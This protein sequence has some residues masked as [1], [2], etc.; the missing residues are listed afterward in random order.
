MW[1]LAT[2][3]QA[4]GWAGGEKVIPLWP[5]GLPGE[6]VAVGAEQATPDGG[7]LTQISEPVVTVFLPERPDER[8]AGVIVC[9]GGAYA[10]LT[11]QWEGVTYAKWLNELGIA[12]F[13]LKYRVK[14]YGAPAPLQDVLRAIRLV[15]SRAAEWGVDPT[16]VGV[17]GSS[18]GGHLA[19][20]AATLFDHA[21]GKTGAALDAV[22]GRPDFAILVYPVITLGEFTHEG[23]L[24][25]LLGEQPTPDRVNRYSTEKQVTAATPPVFLIH[26]Q[27]D[28]LVPVQNSLLFYSALVQAK[29]PAE[30]HLFPRGRHGIGL[31]AGPDGARDWPDM[32]KKWLQALGVLAPQ[33]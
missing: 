29:V 15:R 10:G 5:E 16:R 28:A 20:C 2:A 19:A 23:S 27:E 33:T 17:I 22:S 25:N 32:A 6:K 14:E 4:A 7:W 3:M 31:R 9:P 26:T 11:Y 21:D 18:A 30:M 24:H 12:A 13:V 8:H 1:V